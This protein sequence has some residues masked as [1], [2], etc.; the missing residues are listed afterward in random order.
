MHREDADDLCLLVHKPMVDRVEEFLGYSTDF[1]ERWRNVGEG[2]L[3]RI[4][5]IH[6]M[7]CGI[8]QHKA[9][10]NPTQVFFLLLSLSGTLSSSTSEQRDILELQNNPLKPRNL[11]HG[12]P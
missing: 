12:Q 2:Y 1:C 10:G 5:P 11:V 4:Y 8:G 6:L 9:A 7:C 3:L